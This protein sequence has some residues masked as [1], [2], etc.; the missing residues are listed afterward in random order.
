MNY[1]IKLKQYQ[2]KIIVFNY[3]VLNYFK[4]NDG[5]QNMFVYEPTFSTIKHHNTRAE[6]IISWRTKR[7]YT[8]K[9]TSISN[10]LLPN[11]V[12]FNKKWHYDL[13]VDQ[14]NYSTETVNVYIV[15]GLDYWPENP[16]RNFTLK[17][18][19]FGATNIVKK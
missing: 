13:V 10:D 8:T 1:Q 19:L 16:L 14:N 7:L 5:L 17:T 4:I 15:Y 3:V 12:C 2:Q 9:R 18:C 11:I 6:Y